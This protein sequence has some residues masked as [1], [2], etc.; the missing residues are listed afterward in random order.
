MGRWAGVRVS[1]R[2]SLSGCISK[3]VRFRKL[4]QIGTLVR[5]FRC[6]AS[7]CD[8]DLTFDLAVVTLTYEILSGFYLGFHKVWKVDTW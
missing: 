3:T 8:L 5:R 4:I 7:W 2:K 1:S 6:A